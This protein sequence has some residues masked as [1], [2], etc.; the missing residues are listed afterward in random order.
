MCNSCFAA[1]NIPYDDNMESFFV[2]ETLKYSYL[3]FSS[4]DLVPLDE[5][6]FNT[7]AHP[8]K[9]MQPAR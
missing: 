2:A 4:S 8:L 7:E 9:I 5:Y 3:L 6:V 1:G